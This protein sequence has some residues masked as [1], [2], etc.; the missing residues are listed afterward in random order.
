MLFLAKSIY[1]FFMQETKEISLEKNAW[2]V[3][4]RENPPEPK[5]GTRRSTRAKGLYH[6]TQASSR[7]V[8]AQIGLVAS[9]VESAC[10]TPYIRE[11]L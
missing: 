1:Y 10:V 5:G 4:M 8:Q 7:T 11:K 3:F 6:A 2:E 9:L